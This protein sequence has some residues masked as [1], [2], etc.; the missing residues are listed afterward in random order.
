M[1]E[2][3]NELLLRGMSTLYEDDALLF[4]HKAAEVLFHS[5]GDETGVVEIVRSHYGNARLF[6][7]HRLDK[8][9]SGVMVFAKTADA[10]RSVSSLFEQRKVAKSYVAISDR[11]PAKKQGKVVGDMLKSRG[12]S[13]RLARTRENP[14]ITRFYS[15]SIAPNTWLFLLQPRTGKTHQLRVAL[16]SLGAPI[17]GDARYGGAPYVRTC[18]HA[19]R[20]AF[21]YQGRDYRIEDPHFDAPELEALLKAHDVQQWLEQFEA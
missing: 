19:Y 2:V 17:L 5:S 14:A 21:S 20:I 8:V 4:I 15:R 10:N 11:K 13:Y 12:G 7:V 6:P 1:T 3:A 18:L 16:K 9:T